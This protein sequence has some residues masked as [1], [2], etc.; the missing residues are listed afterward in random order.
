M[1]VIIGINLLSI[2]WLIAVTA[3]RGFE[4]ALPSAAFLMVVLPFESQIR[5][6]GLFDLTT[7]RLIVM[8]LVVLYVVSGRGHTGSGVPPELPNKYLLIVLLAWMGVSTATSVVPDVSFKATLSALLD[9]VVPY[10]I[11]SKVV[12]KPETVHKILSA[13]VAA[14]TVCSVFGVLEIYQDWSVLSLLPSA[15]H[16]FGNMVGALAD[17]GVRAQ[18]TFGHPILFGAALAMGIPI[19]LYLATLPGTKLRKSYLWLSTMLMFLCIYRT[20]SRGPWIAVCLSLAILLIFGQGQIR[21]YLAVVVLL[22]A[23]VLV[24]RPGVWLTVANLYTNT[25]DPETAQGESYQWRYAL[26][27]VAGRALSRDVGRALGGYGPESFYYL[28]LEGEFGG[29]KVRFESCDS[30]VVEL[31][32]DTGYVGLLIVALLL[33]KTALVAFRDYFRYRLANGL[34]LV[35]FSNIAAFVLLMTNVQLFGWGQQSFM[36][37]VL[38]ALAMTNHRLLQTEHAPGDE[39]VADRAVTS[40]DLE[41]MSWT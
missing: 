6:P 15:P 33:F 32:V 35:L 26:Y 2:S 23:T 22:S 12:A 20:T 8:L 14:M 30:S 1:N 34:C 31:M 4:R 40:H 28:G 29:K 13:F 3:K 36:L 19:A 9:F 24:V 10:Y 27:D 39:A 7:Q 11:Y 5:L 21:K 38:M 41:V 37:W 17:R 18:A 16:H 25:L